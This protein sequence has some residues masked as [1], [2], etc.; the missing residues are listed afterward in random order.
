MGK[1]K[2]CFIYKER[3]GFKEFNSFSYLRK[4]PW[5]VMKSTVFWFCSKEEK[6]R[7]KNRKKI[8]C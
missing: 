1:E 8:T 2:I 3:L 7:E 5:I 6:V 4:I